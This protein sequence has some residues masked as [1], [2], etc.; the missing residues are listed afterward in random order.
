MDSSWFK[1]KIGKIIITLSISFVLLIFSSCDPNI[2]KDCDS[3]LEFVLDNKVDNLK[4]IYTLGD[5]IT[6]RGSF[7][8]TLIDRITQRK[9]DINRPNYFY[10]LGIIRIDTLGGFYVFGD[11]KVIPVLG[12]VKPLDLSEPDGPHYGN[13][14]VHNI[15]T[16][17][18]G[19]FNQLVCQIIINR[20][21]TYWMVFDAF[22][23]FYNQSYDY[24]P[25]CNDVAEL[26]TNTNNQLDNGWETFESFLPLNEATGNPSK[27]EFDDLG[28]IVFE[29]K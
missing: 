16:E 25:R 4:P 28:S 5:T 20:K 27:Q 29:V 9:V 14:G 26:F 22:F 23:F 15:T 6:I 11:Y 1:I 2:F 21:G 18:V 12:E 8:D 19:Q 7:S 3:K 10:S 17:K 13:A 24:N